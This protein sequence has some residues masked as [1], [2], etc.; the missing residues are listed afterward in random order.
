MTV[1]VNPGPGSTSWSVLGFTAG[2]SS[3]WT[4]AV[5]GV[6]SFVYSYARTSPIVCDAWAAGST[7]TKA[8]TQFGADEVTTLTVTR[9]GGITSAI[10]YPVGVATFSI[11]GGVLTINCPIDVDLIVEVNGD[12][13]D[14]LCIFADPLK[15]AVPGGALNWSAFGQRAASAVTPASNRITFASAH[16]YIADE[17]V[18]L[19]T[20]GT[21]P[22]AVGG[23]LAALTSYFIRIVDATNIELARFPG[24]PAIDITGAGT[25]TLTVYRT[26]CG[27]TPIYFPPGV[28]D[29]G[30]LFLP[31]AGASIYLDAGA[32]VRGNIDL[33]SAANAATGVTIQGPGILSAAVS[34]SEFVLS[35]SDFFTRIL[36]SAFVGYKTDGTGFVHNTE[37]RDITVTALPY[38]TSFEGVNRWVRT[39]L[40]SPWTWS[41]DGYRISY[42]SSIDLSAS[43]TDC[44]AMVADDVLYIDD[45][46]ASLTA[47]GNF[48]TTVQNA[49]VH[50][51]YWPDPD[52]G[53]V[54]LVEDNDLMH[55]GVADTDVDGTVFPTRGGN[56][57]FKA[58]TDGAV[59][60][61]GEG[62]FDI[63]LRNNRVHGPVRSRL[64]SLAN[65]LYPYTDLG[66][67]TR[68]RRGEVARWTIDGLTVEQVPGQL[69]IVEGLDWE[70][71]PHSLAFRGIR[72]AG[73]LLTAANW[74]EYV[75]QNAYPYFLTVGGQP[76][77]T[78]VDVCNTALDLIGHAKRITSIA[79]PD[80]SAEATV[81]AE[82][83]TDCV[84]ELLDAHQWNFATV[85]RE[86]VALDESDDPAWEYCYEVPEGLLRIISIIPADTPD[87]HYTATAAVPVDYEVHADSD[88]VVRI[89]TDLEDAWI[90]FTKYVT[91]PALFSP[92][93]LEALQW[94]L[95]SRIAGPLIKGTEGAAERDRCMQQ[96]MFALGKATQNDARQQRRVDQKTIASWH[97][98]GAMN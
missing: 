14:T 59:D 11:A 86:L 1:Q 4:V 79:P 69:S 55:Y 15:A 61:Q 24:G 29:I 47:T 77:V 19:L 56:T 40:V 34:T 92:T 96:H 78:T 22:T 91:E 8:W 57:V 52:T 81:C 27:T 82:H 26:T 50:S 2:Q 93:F 45:Y 66:D 63:T 17:R 64:W 72:I 68:D 25:G 31:S 39:K 73:V 74:S 51:T 70:N 53:A 83:Y 13:K 54:Q 36:Y 44:F 87:N 80:G 7:V 60:E 5:N 28:W 89:Y 46:F 42:K 49:I 23:D 85:K 94:K 6:S 90:R 35:L 41:C 43:V 32:V 30:F 48:L 20:T 71:T 75:T 65:K 97:R 12:R 33:R 16:D 76:V 95:A 37:V 98:R 58:W 9:T 10:I 3:V 67:L 84:N 21:F 18:S 88:D 38:Y 62:S